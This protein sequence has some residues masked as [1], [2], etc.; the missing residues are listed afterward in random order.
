MAYERKTK[1][2]YEIQGYYGIEN[3]WEYLCEEET[4]TAARATLKLYN[5]NEM[6]IQHRIKKRRVNIG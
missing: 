5:E 4:Y 2:V 6:D 3:G 1:D